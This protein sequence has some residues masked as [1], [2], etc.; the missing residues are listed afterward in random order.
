VRHEWAASQM[1]DGLAIPSDDAWKA[2]AHVLSEEPLSPEALTPGKT[3]VPQVGVLE[4][5]VHDLGRKAET[6]DRVDARMQLYGEAMAVCG[7]CHKWLG[8]GPRAERER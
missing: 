4:Q 2:G 1:W 7:E 8:G 5:S 6:T 3:P